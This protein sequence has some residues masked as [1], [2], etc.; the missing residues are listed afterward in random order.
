[1]NPTE[2]EEKVDEKEKE[3]TK[4]VSNEESKKDQSPKVSAE[5]TEDLGNVPPKKK[6]SKAEMDRILLTQETRQMKEKLLEYV[7]D[8]I[9]RQ[10]RMDPVGNFENFYSETSARKALKELLSEFSTA[11]EELQKK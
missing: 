4:S 6:L 7:N 1:M 9:V 2:L 8:I 11:S 10:N 5:V 3:D